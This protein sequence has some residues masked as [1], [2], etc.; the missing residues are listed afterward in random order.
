[1]K[2]TKRFKIT[3]NG[4]IKVTSDGHVI[5]AFF[6]HKGDELHWIKAGYESA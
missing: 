4:F 5:T 2:N 1:M 6:Y 3:E